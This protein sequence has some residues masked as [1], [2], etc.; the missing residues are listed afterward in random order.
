MPYPPPGLPL[1]I[2][3]RVNS[4][5]YSRY[6]ILL[7][8][9]VT[10][11]AMVS[12]LHHRIKLLACLQ[13]QIE[14]I[15]CVPCSP[16]CVI[17]SNTTL[18]FLPDAFRIF[19][20]LR[21]FPWLPNSSVPLRVPDLVLVTH[22]IQNTLPGIVRQLPHPSYIMF[23]PVPAPMHPGSCCKVQSEYLPPA[24]PVPAQ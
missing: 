3:C 16:V 23:C 24:L 22:L 9:I 20:L 6:A 11:S 7:A 14:I 17:P 19:E 13:E 21:I 12:L 10:P 8:G 5:T 2:C 18:I 4:R 15:F 1:T